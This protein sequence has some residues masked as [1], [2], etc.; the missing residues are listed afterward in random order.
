LPIY[1]FTCQ[2][3]KNVF[4]AI[5]KDPAQPTPAC[6]ACG[7]DTVRN[8]GTPNAS[9]KETTDEYRGKSRTENTNDLVEERSNEYFKRVMLP[10]I[11]QQ[12]GDDFCIRQGFIDPDTEP[13]K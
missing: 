9:G 11:R 7:K 10:K 4:K 13:V 2:S 1:S 6:K 3:C 8:L 5:L 12:H